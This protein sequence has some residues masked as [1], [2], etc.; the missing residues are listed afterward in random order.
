MPQTGDPAHPGRWVRPDGSPPAPADNRK[1]D[2]PAPPAGGLS[3][4]GKVRD[5]GHKALNTRVGRTLKA[6]ESKLMVVSHKT[7]DIAANAA[8]RRGMTEEN[9]ARLARTLAVADFL[10]GYV[11][12]IAAGA[13]VSPWA[14][15]AASMLPSVSAVYL[16]YSTARNPAA[17]WRAA[18]EVLGQMSL[19]PAGAGRDLL[20]AWRGQE[21]AAHASTF[22][23]GAGWVD[24]LAELLHA[25]PR[26]ADWRQAV[27]LTALGGGAVDPAEA[28]RLAAAAPLPTTRPVRTP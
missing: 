26:L 9:A 17:T 7:R 10:G 12:G 11:T 19:S 5:L 4:W 24:A 13:T 23:A 8:R 1:A 28:V 27:F 14:G 18:R 3:A 6:A 16:A 25:D 20:A 2:A 21:P 22:A 15:K